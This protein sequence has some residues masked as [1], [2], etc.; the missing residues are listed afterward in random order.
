MSGFNPTVSSTPTTSSRNRSSYISNQFAPGN[1]VDIVSSSDESLK[2]NNEERQCGEKDKEN[3]PAVEPVSTSEH[4]IIVPSTQ[5]QSIKEK[6]NENG[7]EIIIPETQETSYAERNP[8]QARVETPSKETSQPIDI[9]QTKTQQIPS[10]KN[11][12]RGLPPLWA[13]L[14]AFSPK[15]NRNH[16]SRIPVS[17]NKSLKVI[18]TDEPMSPKTSLDLNRSDL[19]NKNGESDRIVVAVVNPASPSRETMPSI[20]LNVNISGA[21][22]STPT[23][24]PTTAPS[25][26]LTTAQTP[27]TRKS[28]EQIENP[29]TTAQHSSFN[30]N[31]SNESLMTNDSDS[32][33]DNINNTKNIATP[34]SNHNQTNISVKRR[35]LQSFERSPEIRPEI[36]NQTYNNIESYV[37]HRRSSRQLQRD[38]AHSIGSYA[39]SLPPINSETFD[40]QKS[41]V[42]NATY[43]ISTNK[44]SSR[45][46]PRSLNF[47]NV[48]QDVSSKSNNKRQHTIEITE[49]HSNDQYNVLTSL[50]FDNENT[51]EEI[52]RITGRAND[53]IVNASSDCSNENDSVEPPQQ[54][55]HNSTSGSSNASSTVSLKQ[56]KQSNWNPVIVLTKLPLLEHTNIVNSSRKF[57]SGPRSKK[58]IRES[59]SFSHVV[60]PID[61]C[62]EPIINE[63]SPM[64]A[65]REFEMVIF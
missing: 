43:D 36:D 49:E 31:E 17:T 9:S 26:A 57:I 16:V 45:L 52:V 20:Q 44:T 22:T 60:P 63:K 33:P 10:P 40:K 30:Q 3:R 53:D 47:Q 25:L 29:T 13:N 1:G 50:S 18:E 28:I 32:V 24:A 35:L 58:K 34:T 38:N 55:N 23:L 5:E 61:F 56:D 46:F 8:V 59:E 54:E 12:S 19:N 37:S 62:D 42:Q 39:N 41:A 14:S 11:V 15:T 27:I 51:D 6:Q 4:N 7:D 64:T 48:T 21:P 65:A 2:L